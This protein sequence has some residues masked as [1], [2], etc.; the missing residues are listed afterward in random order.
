MELIE[1]RKKDINEFKNL[2]QDAFQYGY[3]SVHGGDQGQILPDK[4]IDENLNNPSSIWDNSFWRYIIKFR[5]C[6]HWSP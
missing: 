1:L 2:M 5:R 4:D 6:D 3:E